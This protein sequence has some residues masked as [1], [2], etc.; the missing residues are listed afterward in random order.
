M[1]PSINQSLSELFKGIIPNVYVVAATLASFLVLFLVLTYFVYRPL[2]KYIKQRK[3]FLQ[4]HI[5]STI[6]SNN[7]AKELA[8]QSQNHLEET[9]QYCIDLKHESQLEANKLIENSKKQATEEAR[10]LISEGQ[11]VLTEY[12]KEI[13]KKYQENII[14]VAADISKKFLINQEQ[15]NKDLHEKMILDLENLL[16]SE[17]N[18]RE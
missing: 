15:N 5:D 17:K 3:D 12:E 1:Q 4:N 13:V 8:K 6:Q 7:E 11:K 18:I 2:K 10:R 9:K 16:K 14:N